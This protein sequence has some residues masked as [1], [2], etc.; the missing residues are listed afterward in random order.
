[1]FDF[2]LLIRILGL[3]TI[4]APALLTVCLGVPTLLA[5]PLSE[6]VTGRLVQAAIAAALLSSLALLGLMLVQGTRHVPIELGNWVVIPDYDFA[7]KFL[8]DRLSVPFVI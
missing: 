7:V 3:T 8:F 2:D 5:R 4:T 1:M 6:R